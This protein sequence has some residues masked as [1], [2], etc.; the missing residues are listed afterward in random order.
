MN[1]LDSKILTKKII[2]GFVIYI[3]PLLIIGGGL[4]LTK[5][6]LTK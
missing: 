3:V 4:W 2:V 1:I 6:I 5:I